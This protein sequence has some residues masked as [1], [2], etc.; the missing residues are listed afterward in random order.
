MLSF[1]S[2]SG[3]RSR[4]SAQQISSSEPR[5]EVENMSSTAP[6]RS[7]RLPLPGFSGP[8]SIVTIHVSR[9]KRKQTFLVHKQF[10]CFYSSYFN[11]AFNGEFQEGQTQTLELE[12]VFPSLFAIFVNW[13]YTQKIVA[14]D[15]YAPTLFSLIQLWILADRLLV[16]KLQN[17]IL[18]QLEIRRADNVPFSGETLAS[19][20]NH[21]VTGSPLRRYLAAWCSNGIEC[22]IKLADGYPQELLIDIFNWNLEH[23]N[24]HPGYFTDKQIKDLFWVKS[25]EDDV[26]DRERLLGLQIPFQGAFKIVHNLY[27][28]ILVL[29]Y[30]YRQQKDAA[31]FHNCWGT[32]A[33]F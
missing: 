25:E 7:A 24:T 5:G 29:P 22:K 16:P 27:S 18:G 9:N 3:A 6:R 30:L 17:K 31:I 32:Q 1:V 8:Q 12:N 26:I 19:F 15:N 33:T 23:N 21:T 2:G 13:I 10:I 14:D 4:R 20:Y 28:A 11:A